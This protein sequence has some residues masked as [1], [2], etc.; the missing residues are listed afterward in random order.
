MPGLFMGLI[1]AYAGAWML[2]HCFNYFAEF[3]HLTWLPDRISEA[4]AAAF[5]LSPH[6][7][8]VAG[9][10]SMLAI[11]LIGLGIMYFARQTQGVS[12]AV[13]FLLGLF[14]VGFGI[15]LLFFE[16]GEGAGRW[17]DGLVR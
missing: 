3:S 7:F 6:S 11:Q 4:T 1:A 5:R 8:I 10:A 15:Y 2:I 9:M 13:L 14:L 17:L 16:Q 12:G